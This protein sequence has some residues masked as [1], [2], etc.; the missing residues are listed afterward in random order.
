MRLESKHIVFPIL[1]ACMVYTSAIFAESENPADTAPPLSRFRIVITDFDGEPGKWTEMANRL[2]RHTPGQPISEDDFR[3]TKDAL[4]QCGRFQTIDLRE[5]A[6]EDGSMAVLI[7]LTPFRRIKD[8]RIEDASPLFEKEVLNAMTVYTGDAYVPKELDEQEKR[9]GE[10]YRREGFVDPWVEVT[11]DI[12]PEDG[13]ALLFVEIQKK[14]RFNVNKFELN[15]NREFSDT[16][17]K[18]RTDIWEASI[19]PGDAGRF[20]EK[21]LEKDIKNLTEF[22]RYKQYPEVRIDHRVEKDPETHDVDI[23]IDIHEG[24]AYDVEFAGNEEFWNYTLKKDLVI[25]TEGNKH[26][27]GLK[28]SV[29]NIEKRYREA[30]YL[31]AKVKTETAMEETD[32]K[33]TRKVGFL[34]DE[35]PQSMVKAVHIE[36]NTAFDAEKIGK[37]MLTAPPG[38]FHGGAFVRETLEEDIKSVN[39]LYLKEGYVD[40]NVKYSLEWNKEKTEVI[41]TVKISEGNQILVSSVI[42]EGSEAITE[43][44]AL[45]AIHMKPGEPFREYMIQ[46]DENTISAMVSEKGHPHVKTAGEVSFNADRSAA[47]I[48]YTVADGPTVEMGEVWFAGNLKTRESILRDELEI[49]PGEPF[50]LVRMLESQKNIRDM[51]IFDS[52]RFEAVGLKQKSDRVDL[53]VE[54]EEKKPYFLEIG[55]GYDT[56]KQ[57]FVRGKAGNHNLFGLNKDAWIDGEVSQI[58]F[59]GNLGI[60]E[61]R[62]L[63]TRISATG[64][65]FWEKEKEMNKSYGTEIFGASAVFRRKWFD[66]RVNTGLSVGPKWIN[67]FDR[68]ESDEIDDGDQ[69]DL[70]SVLVTTPSISYDSRDSFIIPKKGLYSSFSVDIYKGLEKLGTSPDDVL[71]FRLDTRYFLTPF[72]KIT[73]ALRANTGYIMPYGSTSKAD[74]HDDHMFYSGGTSSVRGFKEN[75]LAFDES[76]DPVGGLFSLNAAF[77]VRYALGFNFELTGFFDVGQVDDLTD[78]SGSTGF[79]STVGAGLRYMTPIGPVGFLYGHKLDKEEN[80]DAGRL[81]FSL[82]YT[83]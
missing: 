71:R 46:S 8:I 77:E 39:A 80:E 60:T 82:G 78:D 16:R 66:G 15:G 19:L 44:E 31:K 63:G 72:E 10:L 17:L 9:I 74:I 49:E 79:R 1:I 27:L 83:F 40:A 34:I 52:V 38:L 64:N 28:K 36:G 68:D 56:E 55:G 75:M 22:Y 70:R 45:E 50:S 7:T 61:P 37:Q 73:F 21:E 29:R 59:R 43:A 42:V 62:L 67:Q 51:N 12:D 18:M 26:D 53:F 65:L 35:G 58:G 76:R 69:S 24:P 25:F 41:V 5:V 30:G 2:V 4:I 32:G 33:K 13:H 48:R 11:G 81:H 23:F 14:E 6:E 57:L 3:L 54:T 20:V 47:K